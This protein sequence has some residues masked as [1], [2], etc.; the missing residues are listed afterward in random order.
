MT[1]LARPHLEKLALVHMRQV[2]EEH[3]DPIWGSAYWLERARQAGIRNA[4]EIQSLDMLIAV[5]QQQTADLQCRPLLDYIPRQYHNQMHRLVIG[6]TGGTTGQGTWTAYLDDEFHQAFVKPFTVAAT[7]ANFPTGLNWLFAGP[8]GPH[9]IGKAAGAIARSMDSLEPFMIDFDPRWSRKMPA[10][11]MG[12][13]RYLQHVIDQAMAVIQSQEI[14]VIFATPPVLIGLADR[15][16]PMQRSSIGGVHYGGMTISD[17]VRHQL[18]H[19]AFPHAVHL[20]GY[21]NT[22][23]GCCMEL[24]AAYS[25]PMDY[26]P[27]SQR[28]IFEVVDKQNQPASQGQVRVTRL[29]RSFMIVG[30]LERD[31][32]AVIQP[33]V[34]APPGFSLTG[35]RA[36]HTPVS[37]GQ[38][39]V[40]TLY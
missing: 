15:M 11:S 34:Q 2:L 17:N 8:S 13:Q 5:F 18:Q 20:S 16:T 31:H 6:Q 26:F 33:P 35:L 37:S 1:V 32:A 12:A 27:Y 24:S 25:Q 28:L 4:S 19:E 36:P 29:D 38:T 9:I 10:G 22:L 39:E 30:L 40:A 7:Q 23:L 21:G 3:L 14:G